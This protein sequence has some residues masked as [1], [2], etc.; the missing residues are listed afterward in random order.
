[1]TRW[2]RRTAAAILFLGV[3]TLTVL[4]DGSVTAPEATATVRLSTV[5]ATGYWEAAA[6]GGIFSFGTAPFLGSMAAQSL[7]APVVGMASI[8]GGSA[9]YYEVAADGGV[10][11]FGVAR[12]F[13]SMGGEH[14]NAPIVGMALGPDITGGYYEVASD[15]GVF[16]FGDAPFL[17]SMAA[18]H[19]DGR[20]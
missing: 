1:M 2:V 17:G 3:M 4:F 19:L 12:F 7:N 9:G 20:S 13:G 6:D 11:G 14:L 10:F 8:P 15:G 18:K 16:A 5:A